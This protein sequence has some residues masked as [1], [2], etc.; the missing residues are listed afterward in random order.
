MRA[1]RGEHDG[2]RRVKAN[3]PFWPTIPLPLLYKLPAKQALEYAPP[4]ICIQSAGN[5]NAA[6]QAIF[7]GFSFTV[8]KKDSTACHQWWS[9]YSWLHISPDLKGNEDPIPF[10]RLFVERVRDGLLHA[11][12]KRIKKQLVEQ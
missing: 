12:G 4:S 10:L 9:F 1:R 7:K 8:F 11:Q 3:S 2:G 5:Y 6:Q